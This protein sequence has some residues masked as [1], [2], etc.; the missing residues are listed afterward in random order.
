MM[1]MDWKT[2]L[3]T[4][5]L[6]SVG[7]AAAGYY[8]VGAE[9]SDSAA[10]ESTFVTPADRT[11]GAQRGGM[12]GG[13]FGLGLVGLFGAMSSKGTRRLVNGSA[14]LLG[15]GGLL[16]SVNKFRSERTAEAP[17]G[18]AS[19]LPSTA[20]TVPANEA[21]TPPA[22]LDAD[23]A[24]TLADEFDGEGTPSDADILAAGGGASS[25]MNG[26]GRLAAM[27]RRGAAPF[28]PRYYR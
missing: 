24:K 18:T 10:V 6:Y 9:H 4:V 14:A 13:L 15:F 16:W 22:Q 27:R 25:G 11:R 1:K 19:V 2:S 3:G 5:A 17:R 28:N 23:I 26:L 21:S 8:A 20:A 12:I 7:G